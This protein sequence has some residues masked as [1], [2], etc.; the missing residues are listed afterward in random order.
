[1]LVK[2]VTIDVTNPGGLTA[3]TSATA[4]VG[5]VACNSSAEL[6][7]KSEGNI[8][9][10]ASGDVTS[11]SVKEGNSVSKGGVIVTLSNSNLSQD[12][13]SAKLSVQEAQKTLDDKQEILDDCSVTA[14]FAGEIA[15]KNYDAGDTLSS[16]STTTT[17]SGSTSTTSSGTVLCS[18]YD[19]SYMTM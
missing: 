13:P 18:I 19:L 4:Q 6:T 5:D 11:I 8:T 1:M 7:Y 3:S 10:K 17:S 9:A 2:Y 15:A 16:G 12:I 14:P